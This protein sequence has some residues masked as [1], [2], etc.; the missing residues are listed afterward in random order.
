MAAQNGRKQN[1]RGDPAAKKAAASRSTPVMTEAR[2]TADGII[3][4]AEKLAGV[5]VEEA[6]KEAEAAVEELLD[7]A[8]KTAD[9]LQTDAEKSAEQVRGSAQETADRL[10]AEARRDSEEL[11]QTTRTEAEKLS[12]EAV[13][14]AAEVRERHEAESERLVAE[15]STKAEKLLDSAS[16]RAEDVRAQAQTSADE[17]LHEANRQ[18]AAVLGEARAKADQISTEAEGA[19]ARGRADAQKIRA[20]AEAEADRA[21]RAGAADRDRAKNEAVSVRA[22]AEQLRQ[23]AEGTAQA[24]RKQAEE[25]AERIRRAATDEVALL[26]KDVAEE[27]E[28]TRRTAEDEAGRLR[29][30]ART[31]VVDSEKLAEHLVGQARE[32][33]AGILARAENQARE[34]TSQADTAVQDA[35]AARIQT[36][37]EADTLRKEA[38]QDRDQAAAELERALSRTL[39]KL[40]KRNLRY[41]DAERR[42][43]TKRNEKEELAEQRRTRRE[44]R[45]A[46]RPTVLDRVQKFFRDNA[47]RLMVIGPISAPMAVAWSSQTSYAMDAFGWWL[48]AALGFAAAWELTTTFTAWMYHQSR[49]QGDSGL[50]YRVMTWVFA[51]GAAAMNYA[52]HCGPNGQPTQAAVAFATMSIVGMILW[53]L[54]ASLLHREHARAEGRVAKAR[55]RIGLIRWVRY[56]RQS[57]TAWSLTINNQALDTL[58]KAWEAAGRHLAETDMIRHAKKLGSLRRAVAVLIGVGQ[59]RPVRSLPPV[60]RSWRVL[61]VSGTASPSGIPAYALLER[62]SAKVPVVSAEALETETRAAL[63]VGETTVSKQSHPVSETAETGSHIRAADET[64]TA[65]TRETRSRETARDQSHQ[66]QETRETRETGSRETARDQSR[67]TGN[68]RS[69]PHEIKAAK[70]SPL[71]DKASETQKL[72]D[73]MWKR[74]GP[75]TVQLGSKSQA[76]EAEAITGRPR[77]T[78]GKRLAEARALYEAGLRTYRETETRA[79]GTDG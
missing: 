9:A 40:Q 41:E 3:A 47:R 72:L 79:T 55:P 45:K 78:A 28:R 19:L 66:S 4:D 77:S 20:E 56:P 8:Q 18:A 65:E 15:A 71:R 27:A 17:L 64:G 74:G 73:V 49:S 35:R 10:L 44:Q 12:A 53:E 31:A 37:T 48:I 43:I 50:I 11:L 1:R 60:P 54:Y 36:N 39:Q 67:G 13:A 16:R 6:V 14:S 30:G 51:A 69:Q 33:A 32:E 68:G 42:R 59:W 70:V 61:P 5:R 46:G 7:E 24:L 34:L 76:G 22:E 57:W 38:A 2:A 62:V 52:H 26:R 23:H 29:T 25:T 58:E 21:R 75:F 63:P